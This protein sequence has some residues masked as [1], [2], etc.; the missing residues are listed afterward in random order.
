MEKLF[1]AAASLVCC[2]ERL[3]VRIII[4]SEEI[5][6][7]FDYNFRDNLQT[8]AENFFGNLSQ[9]YCMNAFGKIAFTIYCNIMPEQ[10]FI[11]IVLSGSFSSY[12]VV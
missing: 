5:S 10:F 8:Q 4:C 3:R 9:L 2:N 12:M 1:L 11:N 6:N 7:Y